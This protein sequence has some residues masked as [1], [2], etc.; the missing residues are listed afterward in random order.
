MDSVRGLCVWRAFFFFF[1]PLALNVFFLSPANFL[2]SCQHCNSHT[3][4]T[5]TTYF[6]LR[7]CGLNS[8]AT[9]CQFNPCPRRFPTVQIPALRFQTKHWE[10]KKNFDPVHL[11]TTTTNRRT[12]AQLSQPHQRLPELDPAVSLAFVC[13][14]KRTSSLYQDPACLGL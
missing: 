10:E 14:N 6:F 7:L 3:L 4:T 2:F 13:M 5:S 11:T 1:L 12:N 9:T 8:G